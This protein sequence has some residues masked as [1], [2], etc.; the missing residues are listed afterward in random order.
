[1]QDLINGVF[2]D[3]Y[4]SESMHNIG[5]IIM[6]FRLFLHPVRFTQHK[7]VETLKINLN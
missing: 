5:S 4:V 6:S 7:V 1:M 2:N 3:T